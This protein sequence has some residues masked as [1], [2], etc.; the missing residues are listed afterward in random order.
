MPSPS[1][2]QTL[3]SQLRHHDERYY[4]QATPEISDADYD[5]LRDRYDRMADELGI[6]PAERY[7][8]SLGDDH[9]DGFVTAVHDQAMLSLEKANTEPGSFVVEGE[10]VPAERIPADLKRGSAWGKLS[11]WAERTADAIDAPVDSLALVVEPKIDGMSV[12]LVYD[13]GK[14]VRAV[15]RGDGV[16]GDVITAQVLAS[17]A[18]PAVV[19]ERKRFEVRGELYLAR[20]AFD[21]LNAK[22]VAGGD[23]PLVNPRNGC[24]GLM[25]RKDPESLAG[26]GVRGF[27]YFVPPGL[28]R[29]SL[30]DSQ[31]ERLRWLT[32]QGFTVHPAITVV[33][34]VAAAYARC[35]AYAVERP[36]L[37]H[38]IDGMVVKLDDTA[39]YDRLGVTE[40]HP[41]WGIAYKFPPERR[42]TVLNGVTIQVG[43]TGRL[44]PVAGLAPVFLAGSTISNA[45]LHNFGYVTAKDVRI[46]D[47]VLIQ[48]AGEIIPQV[49]SVD[50]AKRPANAA[51][52]P[53]PTACPICH[54]AVLEERNPKDPAVVS[55]TCPNEHCPAKIRGT[56][57]HFGIRDAMDI[58]GLGDAVVDMLILRLDVITPDRLYRLTAEQLA[59][60]PLEQDDPAKRRVFGAK[61]AENLIAAIN[62]SKDRGLARVLTGLGV[63][64]LG[65]K[66][67]EDLAKR[68]STWD[69]LLSFAKGY[70]AGERSAVLTINKQWSKGE[71]TEA[72]QLNL[73]P[74]PGIDKR[75]AEP[76]FRALTDPKL[77]GI[78]QGLAEAGVTLTHAG[79]VIQA[80]SGIAGKTFVLTGTLPTLKRHEAEA[81]IVQAGGSCVGS[82]SK[83]TNYVVA[84]DD[85]GSK[86]AKAQ[87]LG[88]PVIDE[89]ELQRMLAG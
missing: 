89:A 69:A 70:L 46:G 28:H 88:V 55:H 48:K 13:E 87:Q 53:W 9:S 86:L 26:I 64:D 76:L 49:L 32:A 75:V 27:L 61:N 59:T 10:D 51:A 80:V 34:G 18:V 12:A 15:T 66:L 77:V 41:R 38:D 45:S 52:I 78:M 85:A 11:A 73:I 22:L 2:L 72:E 62:G 47:T 21:A 68:F 81:L 56:L 8:R 44:T 25:K 65:S 57:L 24:A 74:L 63:P 35:L 29:A 16:R 58:R 43:R 7:T 33:R 50:L 83:K 19:P 82:V 23:K 6:S 37:D 20:A 30:P 54:T 39:M 79:P 4:R 40:H 31:A 84:G 14:L 17:G 5:E 71:R 1:D 60:Q 36:T 67:S 42:A 3:E